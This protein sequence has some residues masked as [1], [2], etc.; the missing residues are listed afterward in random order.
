MAYTG[1]GIGVAD[2]Q[3]DS[4]PM[5]AAVIPDASQH[6]TPPTVQLFDSRIYQ[7]QPGGRVSFISVLWAALAHLHGDGRFHYFR[8]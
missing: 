5:E 6:L 1:S 2:G 8:D 3:A 4:Q 7:P